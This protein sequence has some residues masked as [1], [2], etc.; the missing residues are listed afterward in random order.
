M[1]KNEKRQKDKQRSTNNTHKTKN[2]GKFSV[3]MDVAQS[4]GFLCGVLAIIVWLF[5]PFVLAIFYCLGIC[6]YFKRQL[7]DLSFLTDVVHWS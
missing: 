5:V 4:C 6:S 7:L 2:R 1:T 3:F